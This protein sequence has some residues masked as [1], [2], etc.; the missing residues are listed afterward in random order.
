LL[1]IMGASAGQQ[2]KTE[3]QHFC[4]DGIHFHSP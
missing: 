2:R 1:W 4:C 3:Q